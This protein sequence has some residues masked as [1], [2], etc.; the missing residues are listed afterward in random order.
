MK[1]YPLIGN[2]NGLQV[3]KSIDL[4]NV[5]LFLKT[6][7][8]GVLMDSQTPCDVWTL[9]KFGEGTFT[10]TEADEIEYERNR[11]KLD[12][13][14]KGDDQPVEVSFEGKA[15]FVTS[16]IGSDPAETATIHEIVS[17]KNYAE[18]GMKFQ[19]TGE[20]WLSDFG[21]PPYTCDLE[22]HNIP[23]LECPTLLV[24]GEAHLFRFFRKTSLE[25]NPET[26]RV[27]CRGACHI[28]EPF[29]IRP[30]FATLY[31]AE[32]AEGQLREADLQPLHDLGGTWPPDPRE[33]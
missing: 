12:D 22:L 30:N 23:Q 6:K 24:H 17:G 14:N 31:A 26:K 27:N 16:R 8:A 32:L 18:G 25:W 3:G 4:R 20:Q 28:T 1:K 10:Y 19:G 2:V 9:M 13:V 21:C 7:T 11:G 5:A 29:V 33:A 15:T